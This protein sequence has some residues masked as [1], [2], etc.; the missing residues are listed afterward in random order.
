[1]A[2]DL[3]NLVPLL[4]R[5]GKHQDAKANIDRALT[6]QIAQFGAD[7]PM[8][9]G[10]MLASANMAYEQGQ[11]VDARNLA[12][13]ARQIQERTFGPEHYAL[14][15]S[16]IFSARLDIA[17]GR[18]RDAGSSTVN[19]AERVAKTLPSDHPSNIDVLDGKADVAR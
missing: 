7:S 13:R 3:I 12:D 6:I 4:Q 16:S 9:V 1:V 14:A 17:Q 8:T 18:R 19:A 11:Y 2:A 15:G 5:A 10:I